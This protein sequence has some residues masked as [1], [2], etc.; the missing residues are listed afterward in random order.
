MQLTASYIKKQTLLLSKPHKALLYRRF[1]KTNL[2]EY[3]ENFIFL[4]ISVP[5]LRI[6]AKKFSNI[7]L[8]DIKNLL[9]SKYHE[10]KMLALLLLVEKY[11]K[12]ENAYKTKI[13]DFYLKNTQYINSWDLVDLTAEKIIGSYLQ[14][15]NRNILYLMAKSNNFWERR[16]SIVATHKFIRNHD[17]ITTLE[18]AAI[19]LNDTEDIIHKAVGWM[20]R[21]IGKRSMIS[22]EKFL[23]QNY[24]RMPRIMLRYAIELFSK[25]KRKKYISGKI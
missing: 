21:E 4:G 14:D 3:G 5:N 15:K 2:G 10:I 12:A 9:N 23:I 22:E 13:F 8:Y 1:H 11:N 17:F 24:K 25:E 6:L 20:I 7:A 19:L 16:I 18:I